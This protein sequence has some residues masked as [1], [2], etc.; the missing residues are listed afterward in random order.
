[1]SSV[2][3]LQHWAGESAA[4]IML[5]DV[6]MTFRLA[7]ERIPTL[8]EYSVRWVQRRVTYHD[9][10]A[11]RHVSCQIAAGEAVGIIGRNGAGKS[12]LLKIIA[13]IVKP[14]S[15]QVVVRGRV[16]P[17][18]EL[19]A[20]FDVELT[21]RENV[22]L[23]GAILGFS[24]RQM[25]AR[26]SRIVDFAELHTFIDAPL[27]TYSSGMITRLGFA[28][29]TEVDP[30]ILLLDE[31]LAV[32]D[33]RFQAKCLERIERFRRADVTIALVSHDATAI[34]RMC[35]RALWLEEGQL[36]A[37]GPVVDVLAQYHRFLYGTSREPA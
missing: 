34:Q 10:T 13:G 12:T 5:A 28:I 27:R 21:G 33:E 25:Q 11:L 1:M 18:I 7:R 37:A 15:G 6:G 29:A 26:F 4:S 9:F 3:P 8:K 36:R 23:N 31:V 35:T 2:Q 17:L 32:G 16:A 14:T 19:G 20:G 22:Y 24:R 30:A